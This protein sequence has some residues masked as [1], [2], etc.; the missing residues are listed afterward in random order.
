[1]YT[2]HIGKKFLELYNRKTGQN[3]SAKEYFEKIHHPLFYNN[4]RY[5]HS[6]GNTPFFQLIAKHKT[7]DPDA[8]ENA[9][10]ELVKKIDEFVSNKEDMA[11]MSYAIGYPAAGEMGTTSGQIS[12]L[13]IPIT[14]DDLYASW[15]GVSMGVGIQG[16]YNVLFSSEVIFEKI[17]EGYPIYRKYVNEND[18]IKNKIDTWNSVWF[19]H[20][21]SDDFNA[22]APIANFQPVMVSKK[23]EVG[24]QRPSWVKVVM[25]LSLLMPEKKISGYVYSLGQMNKTI[26][27][28]QFNLPAINSLSN[29]YKELFANSDVLRNKRLSEIYN[30]ELG[31]QAA[32]QKGVIGLSSLQPKDLKKYMPGYNNNILPKLKNDEKSQINYYMYQL[33]IIAMLNNKELLELAENAA[34]D[35]IKFI[36]AEKKAKTSRTRAVEELLGVKNRKEFVKKISDI[37]EI[38]KDYSTIADHLVNKVMLDIASD[39]ITLFVTL[40]RFKYLSNNK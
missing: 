21:L 24:I 19:S 35:L 29:I 36:Q 26:G 30:T 5:L 32:C 12:N 31:F 6:P 14:E 22:Q 8:R 4:E 13:K 11:N 7:N 3:L 23:G 40:L 39:N 16:G 38:D 34:K 27:F 20:R 37:V 10:T 1:M 18:A 17:A 33:W 25:S 15:I 9:K 28:I 2:S